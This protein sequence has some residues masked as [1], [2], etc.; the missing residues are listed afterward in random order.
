MHVVE[1]GVGNGVSSAFLLRALRENGEGSLVSIDLPPHGV[2]ESTVGR[3][4]PEEL[5]ARWNLRF[6]ASKH[7]LQPLLDELGTIGMFVHDSRHS[8]RNVARELRTMSGRLVRPGAVVVDDAERHSAFFDYVEM[9][10]GAVS[11]VLVPRT[12]SG[13]VGAAILP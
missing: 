9:V 12:K 5:S 11:G 10:D 2:T 3:F 7:L 1:T 6:G 13:L 8:Y 4:V